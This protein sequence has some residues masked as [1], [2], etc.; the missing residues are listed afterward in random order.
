MTA[1]Q[2]QGLE[3]TARDLQVQGD[4]AHQSL[5]NLLRGLRGRRPPISSGREKS[6]LLEG[7]DGFITCGLYTRGNQTGLTWMTQRMPEFV[8]YVK[9]YFAQHL[10]QDFGWTS[11]VCAFDKE[12]VPLHKDVHNV[13][14]NAVI[15][16]GS[17]QGGQ[18]W[19]ALDDTSPDASLVT[20]SLP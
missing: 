16:L 17:F 18:L 13:G 4:Y 6:V 20:S 19:T 9:S 10:P 11:F 12:E 15:G 7:A 3:L 8:K 1:A 14:L 2:G 5:K